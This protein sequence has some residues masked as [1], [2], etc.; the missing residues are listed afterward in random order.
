MSRITDS[1]VDR[2]VKDEKDK[3]RM[4]VPIACKNA[5]TVLQCLVS[6]WCL[7]IVI[8]LFINRKCTISFIYNILFF[9]NYYGVETS[10]N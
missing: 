1:I 3:K 6:E 2:E 9:H 8:D 7:P 4:T 5:R 10:L